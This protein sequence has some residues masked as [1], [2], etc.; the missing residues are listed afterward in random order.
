MELGSPS[1][2]EGQ[3]SV[4]CPAVLGA[5]SPTTPTRVA[6]VC[7]GLEWCVG[8]FGQKPLLHQK[9]VKVVFELYSGFCYFF[10]T[11]YIL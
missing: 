10:K 3:D 1:R 11:S 9:R 4:N 5:T 2:R 7:A 6:E 8:V